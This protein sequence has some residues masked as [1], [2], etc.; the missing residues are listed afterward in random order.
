MRARRLPQGMT[1]EKA[2]GPA[3][4]G[5]NAP[6]ALELSDVGNGDG[7]RI[8]EHRYELFDHILSVSTEVDVNNVALKE[9][10]VSKDFEPSKDMILPR[11]LLEFV[12]PSIS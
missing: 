1:E 3:G 7:G 9:L 8:L 6:S 5:Q 11:L 12:K 4:I 10:E 2:N